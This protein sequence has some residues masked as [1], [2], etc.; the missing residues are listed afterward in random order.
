MVLRDE[1]LLADEG[2]HDFADEEEHAV[3]DGPGHATDSIHAI[4]RSSI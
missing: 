1:F 3:P 4:N 2:V